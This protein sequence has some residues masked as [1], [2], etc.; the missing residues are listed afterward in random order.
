MAGRGRRLS[1]AAL[2]VAGMVVMTACAQTPPADKPRPCQSA[3]YRQFDFWVGRWDVFAP[4]GQRAG[5]NTIEP[6]LGG[7]ALR[8]SWSGRGGFTGT[9]LN[10]YDADDRRW[11]QSWLD[12]QGGRLELAG[13]RV[14]DAM[15][16]ASA[17]PHATK[18]GVTL[19]QR[20]TW[21]PQ[22]DGA[23]RQL[24]ETSEDDGA[25]WSVAFDGRYVR[26]P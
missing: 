6:I 14:G 2:G 21:T 7:C 22:P 26:R 10:A 20:I 4:D 18:P 24:W 5:E 19:R 25:T 16:L 9:S 1:R 13:T 12:N 11:H 23:V 3:E 17:T 8:E 15:V